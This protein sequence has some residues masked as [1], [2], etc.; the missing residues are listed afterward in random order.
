MI[1]V[2]VGFFLSPSKGNGQ[3]EHRE[4]HGPTVAGEQVPYDGGRDGGVAGLT[5]AHQ[6][7]GQHKQ[8]VVLQG[9]TDKQSDMLGLLSVEKQEGYLKD[10]VTTFQ[11]VFI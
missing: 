4:H 1:W 11:H 6:A 9:E 10:D 3:I 7:S 5:D 2:H 8:P